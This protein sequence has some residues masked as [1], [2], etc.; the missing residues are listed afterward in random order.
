MDRMRSAPRSHLDDIF[1][2]IN[3]ETH[4]LWR[5]LDHEGEIPGSY[6]TER[7]DRKAALRFVRT[8]MERRGQPKL[9]V[10]GNL[11]SY[12]AGLGDLGMPIIGKSV[13]D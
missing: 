10:T 5:A 3:G 6:V 13:A 8:S 4:Y 12:G 11:R 7:R 1:V 2:K 9:I